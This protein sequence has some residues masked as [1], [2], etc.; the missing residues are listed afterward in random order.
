M[1]GR[2]SRNSHP[3]VNLDQVIA[4]FGQAAGFWPTQPEVAVLAQARFAD[5]CRDAGVRPVST[6]RFAETWVRLAE[7]SRVRF[8]IA[9]AALDVEAVRN[10]LPSLCSDAADAGV[11]LNL[12]QEFAERLELLTA[13]MI[14]QSDVRL[15]EFARHF[16]AM[17]G[18]TIEEETAERSAARLHE[19]NFARLM[20]EADAARSSAEDRM[21]Y[22]RKLQEEQEA[23]RRPRR[24]KW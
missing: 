4:L 16:C 2:R 18:L 13:D 10:R 7:E 6:E 21:A 3:L 12:L 20:K 5:S 1:F 17:A 22:L 19:I 11:C 14:Q 15:E 9:L 23:T 8:C 24:G